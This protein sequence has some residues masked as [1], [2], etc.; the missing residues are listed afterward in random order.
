MFF[1]TLFDLPP[2]SPL[3]GKHEAQKKMEWNDM[4][5][6]AGAHCVC[7]ATNRERHELVMVQWFS[8]LGWLCK[9]TRCERCGHLF[10]DRDQCVSSSKVNG[11]SGN[12][13]CYQTC[14]DECTDCGRNAFPTIHIATGLYTTEHYC[15]SCAYLWVINKAPHLVGM[16]MNEQRLFAEIK[17]QLDR[18][19][20]YTLVL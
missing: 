10:R 19:Q 9:G 20:G 8:V 4:E 12:I 1:F 3:A 14:A 7:H 16:S 2:E 5:T 15:T 6:L 11:D 17:R 13:Y 18:Q